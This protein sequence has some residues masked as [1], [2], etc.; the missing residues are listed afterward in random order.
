MEENFDHIQN[1][2][3]NSTHTHVSNEEKKMKIKE[4]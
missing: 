2:Y 4:N 3:V 1:A